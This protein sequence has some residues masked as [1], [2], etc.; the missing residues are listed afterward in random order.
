[1]HS[2][3]NASPPR[4]D[5]DTE[6][7]AQAYERDCPGNQTLQGEKLLL[8]LSLQQG[9]S[10]LDVGTG[11]GQLAAIAA[12]QVGPGGKVV[13]IDPL[14]MRLDRARKRHAHLKHLQFRCEDTKH[15]KLHPSNHYD[16]I[17]LNEVLAWLSSPEAA[18]GEM[19]R[20]LACHGRIGLQ[21]SF[22]SLPDSFLRNDPFVSHLVD[23]TVSLAT[24]GQIAKIL[25]KIGFRCI[26]VQVGKATTFFP[27]P[28][29]L[30]SFMESSSFN[31]YLGRLPTP[32]Q[33]LARRRLHSELESL[34]TPHG[35]PLDSRI[36]QVT[37]VK[38]P[39]GPDA[40]FRWWDLPL[41]RS[42]RSAGNI[43]KSSMRAPPKPSPEA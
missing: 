11:T 21:S 43:W 5:I 23:P 29:H 10:V 34:R 15:L 33:E 17:Y 6:E 28:E 42:I 8:R 16:C 32:L 19:Y 12:V 25:A 24:H 26:S 27:S 40:L 30:I 22:V 41:R 9:E 37:A 20:C 18:L 39:P 1:V 38:P 4:F 3:P 13:A 35:F 14:P 7:L 31:N 2:K 36:L